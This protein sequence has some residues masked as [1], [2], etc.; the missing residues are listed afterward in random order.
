[1]K[2]DDMARILCNQVADERPESKFLT[3]EDVMSCLNVKKS[4]AYKVIARLNKELK[5][6]GLI[7]VSGRVSKKYF[8]ERFYQ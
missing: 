1:M 4:M 2:K 7:T 5:A 8:V 3:Y 6:K